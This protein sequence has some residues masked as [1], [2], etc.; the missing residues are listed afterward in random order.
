M[1][2]TLYPND[3][4]NNFNY[5]YWRFESVSTTNSNERIIEM[6]IKKVQMHLHETCIEGD[7]TSIFKKLNCNKRD[8][9]VDC[10]APTYFCLHWQGQVGYDMVAHHLTY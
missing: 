5:G 9:C 10:L 8:I 2:V 7:P 6:T 1:H 4:C 3:G